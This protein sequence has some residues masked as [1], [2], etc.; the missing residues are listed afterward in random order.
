M[1]GEPVRLVI[2]DGGTPD[3]S[4]DQYEML[5]PQEIVDWIEEQ[6]WPQQH[7]DWHNPPLG[8]RLPAL[9]WRPVPERRDHAGARAQAGSD[10]GGRAR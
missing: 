5:P 2:R 7:G 6:G 1:S 4:D 8:P 10:P 9:P 3:P